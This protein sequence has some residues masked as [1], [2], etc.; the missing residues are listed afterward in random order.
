VLRS[1]EEF[2]EGGL[3]GGGS[4]GGAH[5]CGQKGQ[6]GHHW[7][8]GLGEGKRLVGGNAEVRRLRLEKWVLNGHLEEVEDTLLLGSS[9]NVFGNLC[10]V[11]SVELDAFKE[12]K[13]EDRALSDFFSFLKLGRPGYRLLLGPWLV[14]ALAK[15]SHIHLDEL[16]RRHVG[17][18]ST[19]QEAVCTEIKGVHL[20]NSAIAGMLNPHPAGLAVNIRLILGQGRVWG[21][22]GEG[23]DSEMDQRE[24]QQ[25]QKLPPF[26][27]EGRS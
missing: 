13:L 17:G 12:K 18:E 14:L 23:E 2:R 1:L 8:V 24:K 26:L 25:Q 7:I 9:P 20:A 6:S 27:P 3:G 21:N 11:I 19:L 22:W 4:H 15:H 5:C 10:P 16:P